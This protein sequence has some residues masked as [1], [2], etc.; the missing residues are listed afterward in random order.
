MVTWG[1]VP[2]LSARMYIMMCFYG[3]L[4]R[5][6]AAVSRSVDRQSLTS[7][8]VVLDLLTSHLS[9]VVIW[10]KTI[11]M[12]LCHAICMMCYS[13][14][15]RS[16]FMPAVKH[17]CNLYGYLLSVISRYLNGY[18]LSIRSCFRRT[19]SVICSIWLLTK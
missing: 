17:F 5:G 7:Q 11:E 9:L 14:S 18:S 12:N 19:T 10:K 8:S 1:G 6:A 3:Y 16:C 4:G 2:L 13:L 15:I